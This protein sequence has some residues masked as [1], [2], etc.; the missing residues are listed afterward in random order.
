[1]LQ[2]NTDLRDLYAYADENLT[3]F[4]LG[5]EKWNKEMLFRLCGSS[6]SAFVSSDIPLFNI[7]IYLQHRF[8]NK[9]FMPGCKRYYQPTVNASMLAVIFI[10]IP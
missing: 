10:D 1:L 7:C 6:T 3:G 4:T 8:F 9:A 2:K 5:F